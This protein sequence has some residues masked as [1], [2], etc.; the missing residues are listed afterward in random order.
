[1]S[2]SGGLAAKPGSCPTVDG[3]HPGSEECEWDMDCPGWQKCCQGP[4][5]SSCSHPASE[6]IFLIESFSFSLIVIRNACNRNCVAVS[7]RISKLF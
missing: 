4:D 5:E 6:Y 1:M 3:L 7:L 2:R